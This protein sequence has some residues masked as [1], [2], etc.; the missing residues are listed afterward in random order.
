MAPDSAPLPRLEKG[1]T[2]DA[3]RSYTLSAPYYT[4][5]EIFEREKAAIF[6]KTWQLVGHLC[7]FEKAGDYVLADMTQRKEDARIELRKINSDE[8]WIE[9]AIS[10]LPGD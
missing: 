2:A 5:P 8:G 3:R 9:Q 4:D 6:C 1:L 10:H 7:Q